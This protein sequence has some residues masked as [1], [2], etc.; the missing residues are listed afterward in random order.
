MRKLFF[1]L[2][3]LLLALP[4][5]ALAE[6]SGWQNYSFKIDGT[7]SVRKTGP[8]ELVIYRGETP[9]RPGGDA[10]P[11]MALFVTETFVYGKHYA[12]KEGKPDDKRN[13]YSIVPRD[14]GEPAGP[15]DEA[16]FLEKAG[17]Q[18]EWETVRQTYKRALREGR[19]DYSE[20]DRYFFGQLGFTLL[21]LPYITL[22]SF[23]PGFLISF[24][25]RSKGKAR[26]VIK[27]W[28]YT[29]CTI[30]SIFFLVAFAG[31]LDMR[32]F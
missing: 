18:K 19:A 20:V 13:I 10:G 30:L 9:L 3:L 6:E 16:A 15:L 23:L 24:Y 25:L 2:L 29:L 28:L 5:S 26:P 31:W 22:Y 8:S 27:G 32:F 12:L 14:G 1:T 7:Y 4:F 21:K 11:L 17:G